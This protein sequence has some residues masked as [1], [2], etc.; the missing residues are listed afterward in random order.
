MDMSTEMLAKLKEK[1]SVAKVVQG[2]IL[3][4][5]SEEKYNYIFIS[6]GSVSLFTDMEM[7]RA[8]LYK[9]KCLLK[10]DGKFVLRLIQ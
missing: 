2:D 10:K 9:M 1:T 6:S 5:D 4:Y 7:C 3:E 8:I